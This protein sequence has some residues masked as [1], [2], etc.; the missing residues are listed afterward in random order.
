MVN[1]VKRACDPCHR[2]K[3]KCDGAGQGPRC[4]NCNAAGLSCTYNAVPQKKGP[5]GSRAKVI[6]ELRETQ[7][8]TSLLARIQSRS[9]PGSAAPPP[10]D[11]ALAAANGPSPGL[12]TNEVVKPSLDYF[13]DNL[14]PNMP[15]FDRESLDGQ[16]IFMEQNRDVYCLVTAL[17]AFVMLQPGMMV[18]TNPDVQ[19]FHPMGG[20][21]NLVAKAILFE[22]VLR[23][24][25]GYEYLEAPTFNA[26][27]TSYL[28]FAC[29]VGE[30]MH[31][32]AWYYL[33]EASTLL[34]MLDMHKEETYQ[35]WKPAEAAKRRRL[36]WLVATS[37]R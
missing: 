18:P 22:E 23:V 3:V 34:H 26:V 24:R 31:N 2:R 9:Y 20:N 25:A 13:F 10:A 30:E 1:P 32:R 21:T 4:N 7:R 5:K 8:I 15:I 12:V 6:S 35:S 27:A 11:P 29:C 33:R 14:Y 36:Y 17:C 37:E 28:L 19:D 16:G